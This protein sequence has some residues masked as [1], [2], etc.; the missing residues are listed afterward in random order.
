MPIR[1][2]PCMIANV[3]SWTGSR[4]WEKEA[5]QKSAPVTLQAGQKYYIQALGKEGAGGDSIAV[6]WQG[7]SI[8]AREVISGQYVDTF[9]L[10]PLAGVHPEP[11]Q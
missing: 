3:A 1:P 6:A 8:A 9:A 5:N 11:G 10:P 7:G 2:T 4:E